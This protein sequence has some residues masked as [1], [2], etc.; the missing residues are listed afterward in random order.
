MWNPHIPAVLEPIPKPIGTDDG[1]R[2]HDRARPDRD[3]T[4]QHRARVNRHL[5]SQLAPVAN[6]G[7]WT[8]VAAI[9]NHG[10]FADKRSRSDVNLATDHRRRCHMRPRGDPGDR[11]LRLGPEDQ[12]GRDE[13]LLSVRGDQPRPVILQGIGPLLG[14]DDRPRARGF[15]LRQLFSVPGKREMAAISFVERTHIGQPQLGVAQ[16]AATQLLCKLANRNRHRR[17]PSA[18]IACPTSCRATSSRLVTDSMGPLNVAFK[19]PPVRL[20]RQSQRP[21]RGQSK[22]NHPFAPVRTRY[23][24]FPAVTYS[25]ESSA[26]RPNPQLVGTS[27]VLRKATSAPSGE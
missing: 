5:I 17:T 11:P 18:L 23:R 16:N 7:V 22:A 6:D 25:V 12:H 8:D 26:P 1:P 19:G 24:L 3:F 15:G 10:V 9:S 13:C 14:D 27:G 4:I 20:H 21:R 2:V